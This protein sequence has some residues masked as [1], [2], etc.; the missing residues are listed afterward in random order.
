MKAA[1][2]LL[3]MSRPQYI[4]V[5]EGFIS[6]LAWSIFEVDNNVWDLSKKPGLR[7]RKGH[8]SRPHKN[9]SI[10]YTE[11]TG[12][13]RAVFGEA[14][15]KNG[16]KSVSSGSALADAALN[17]V[18]GIKVEKGK[19]QPAS[20]LSPHLAL[21]QNMEGIHGSSNP[22]PTADILE[23]IFEMGGRLDGDESAAELW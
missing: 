15:V 1:V 9:L 10:I 5:V 7:Y 17:S 3:P 4:S 23:T 13:S 21:L 16:L 18:V 11:P 8:D 19:F 14:L 22:P 2:V 12:E 20:P 6:S